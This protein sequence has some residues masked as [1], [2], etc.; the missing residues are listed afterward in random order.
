MS[1]WV[2]LLNRMGFSVATGKDYLEITRQAKPKSTRLETTAL[3]ILKAD[4]N[5]KGFHDD[6]GQRWVCIKARSGIPDLVEPRKA[7]VS[8]NTMFTLYRL[9]KETKQWEVNPVNSLLHWETFNSDWR[10]V[11]REECP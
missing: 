10:I 3:G 11:P 9:N 5:Q 2:Q 7:K 8:D 4:I 1:W 6:S